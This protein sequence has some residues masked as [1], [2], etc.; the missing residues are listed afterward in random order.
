MRQGHPQ[1]GDAGNELFCRSMLVVVCPRPDVSDAAAA[2][3]V[4]MLATAIAPEGLS[5]Q[6]Q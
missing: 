4:E 5:Q 2:E 3:T 6:M 1:L